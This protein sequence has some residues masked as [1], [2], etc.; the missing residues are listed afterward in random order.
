LN[1]FT[2]SYGWDVVSGNLSKSTFFE[3]V[4]HFECKF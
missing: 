3:G 4:S 1:F 2:V